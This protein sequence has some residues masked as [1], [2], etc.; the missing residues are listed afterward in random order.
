MSMAG[1]RPTTCMQCD[2]TFMDDCGDSFC[3][4]SCE[5]EYE[6]EHAACEDCGEEVG[7]ENLMGGICSDCWK[8]HSEE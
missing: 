3:S 4:D 8:E 2:R 7:D 6:N 1:Y 5:R